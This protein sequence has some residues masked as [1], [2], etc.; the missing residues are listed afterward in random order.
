MMYSTR[1]HKIYKAGR[2]VRILLKDREACF[3][4]ACV[5]ILH[6]VHCFLYAVSDRK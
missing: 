4:F 1:K 6:G 5:K 3:A 2:K